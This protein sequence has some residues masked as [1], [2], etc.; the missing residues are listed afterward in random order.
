MS[1]DIIKKTLLHI[2]E[3]VPFVILHIDKDGQMKPHLNTA[4]IA[5]AIFIAIIAGLFATHMTVSEL[6]VEMVNIKDRLRQL[7]NVVIYK[8]NISHDKVGKSK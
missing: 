4:R 2:V 1:L 5:E 8:S 3:Y 7:E 6:K